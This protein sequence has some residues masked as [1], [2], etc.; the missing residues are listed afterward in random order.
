MRMFWL[1]STPCDSWAFVKPPV[2]KMF[3]NQWYL[4]IRQQTTKGK[5]SIWA[6]WWKFHRRAQPR[7]KIILNAATAFLL[8]ILGCNNEKKQ[9]WEFILSV[10]RFNLGAIIASF[11]YWKLGCDCCFQP[12]IQFRYH[13]C[14]SD[15]HLDLKRFQIGNQKKYTNW[16]LSPQIG[17]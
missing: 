12:A 1:E 2:R 16:N 5:G 6:F 10:S 7:R 15:S 9:P 11:R 4:A 13:G 17:R 3:S 14:K 8:F